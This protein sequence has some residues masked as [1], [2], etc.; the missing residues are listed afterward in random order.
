MYL[1]FMFHHIVLFATLIYLKKS[2]KFD[3]EGQLSHKIKRV[4]V[5][6]AYVMPVPLVIDGFNVYSILKLEKTLEY[7]PEYKKLD[8]E[9]QDEFDQCVVTLGPLSW[10]ICPRY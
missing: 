1:P 2:S 4:L 10:V 8:P 5:V 6:L 7:F 3:N 9:L